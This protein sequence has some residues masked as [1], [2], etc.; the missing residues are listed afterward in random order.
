[1][2]KIDFE[3][4]RQLRAWCLDAALGFYAEH[5]I[6]EA[7]KTAE[8]FYKFIAVIKVGDKT[9]A[10]LLKEA[11]L[12]AAE[13]AKTAPVVHQ[14]EIDKAVDTLRRAMGDELARRNLAVIGKFKL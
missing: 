11:T 9:P 13:K 6:D 3:S 14:E 12:E 2:D 8:K 5:R 4:E 1:M 10:T 7:I